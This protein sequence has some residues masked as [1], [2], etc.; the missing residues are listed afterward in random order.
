MMRPKP[1]TISIPIVLKVSNDQ[2]LD[3]TVEEVCIPN[4]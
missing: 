1:N 2:Y 3:Q 4:K